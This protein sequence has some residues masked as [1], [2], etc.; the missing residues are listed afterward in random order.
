MALHHLTG[1]VRYALP[2]F[3]W[4]AALDKTL[5]LGRPFARA[6][7]YP[8][9]LGSREAVDRRTSA[10]RD[11]AIQPVDFCIDLTVQAIPGTSLTTGSYGVAVAGWDTADGW[12][13]FLTW[14]VNPRHRFLFLADRTLPEAVWTVWMLKPRAG[15]DSPVADPFRFTR[16]IS[17]TLVNADGVPFTGY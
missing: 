17:L 16:Q 14:A 9:V 8:E 10:E 5:E 11:I 6:V 13:D 1:L 12:R 15:D 4:G 3:V 7:T 2:Q